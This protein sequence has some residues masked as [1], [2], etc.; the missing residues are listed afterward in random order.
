MLVASWTNTL[1]REQ[2][3]RALS[4]EDPFDEA[5]MIDDHDD[6]A[7]AESAPVAAEAGGADAAARIPA[8]V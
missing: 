2:L 5:T 3:D 8:K 4:G 6:E 7:V 1:D